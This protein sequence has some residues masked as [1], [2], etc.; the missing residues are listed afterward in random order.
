MSKLS[1][2]VKAKRSVAR[3]VL[4]TIALVVTLLPVYLMGQ[5]AVAFIG[6]SI[7]EHNA[8]EA[9][10][11]IEELTVQAQKVQLFKEPVVT[12]T[13]DDGWKSVSTAAA[14]LLSRY[15]VA[16]T[17]YVVPT[18][19]G[20][21]AYMTIGQIRALQKAGH[22][23]GSH[24]YGHLSMTE[25]DDYDVVFQYN[26]SRKLLTKYGL[27]EED[28]MSF[29][30]P[31]GSFN[32]NA[33]ALGEPYYTSLRTTESSFTNGIN[34]LDVNLAGT[35]NPHRVV[36]FTVTDET[37]MLEIQS[38]IDYAVNNNGWLVLTF[39]GIDNEHTQYSVT[40]MML[41]DIL[42]IIRQSELKVTTM[43]QAIQSYKEQQ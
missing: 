23:I 41:E 18:Y 29:A 25:I 17:Q 39:H 6:G 21:E 40:P 36:A 32:T 35:F 34:H 4:N 8:T 31:Y 38:L 12:V 24:G 10:Q 13:F 14:P 33:I 22:E 20:S 3:T 7:A 15:N 27:G 19:V 1:T 42:R 11:K 43:K 16:S 37:T 28:N 2:S 5:S 30:F 26:E 9:N